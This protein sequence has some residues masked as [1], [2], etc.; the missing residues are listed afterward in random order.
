MTDFVQW[1]ADLGTFRCEISGVVYGQA[2]QFRDAHIF[3]AAFGYDNAVRDYLIA[4]KQADYDT[5]LAALNQ[6]VAIA[7]GDAAN[8]YQQYQGALS[9]SSTAVTARNV[10][11][12][13]WS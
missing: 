10:F 4:Q 7:D 11:I 3:C 8:L 13:G 2:G 6:A 12:A 5:K 9:A 1:D